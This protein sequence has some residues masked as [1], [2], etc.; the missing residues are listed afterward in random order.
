MKQKK[1]KAAKKVEPS[2]KSDEEKV[3]NASKEK[4]FDIASPG[5]SMPSASARPVIVTHKPNVSDPMVS[6]ANQKPKEEESPETPSAGEGAEM[7]MSAPKKNRIEPLHTDIKPD[8]SEVSADEEEKE[9]ET[10]PDN[11]PTPTEVPTSDTQRDASQ[12]DEDEASEEIAD[13]A[14]EVTTKK[15]AQSEAAKQE[16]EATKR[17]AEIESL[18]NNKQFFVP[19]NAV[20]K[21]RSKKLVVFLFIVVV[22]LVGIL[23]AWDAE[24]IDLG[25]KAPSGFL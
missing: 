21:R 22:F 18:I 4:V 14:S 7:V 2:K 23:I 12:P 10:P 11:E 17:Q 16:A 13:V 20:Q 3:A 5:K 15:Q 6:P 9:K 8:S 19:I 1:K 24:I 25:M